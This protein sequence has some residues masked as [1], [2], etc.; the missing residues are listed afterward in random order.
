MPR[1]PLPQLA[2]IT[3]R[4]MCA[5]TGKL[6]LTPPLIPWPSAS[7]RSLFIE[8]GANNSPKDGSR[9]SFRHGAID[10]G[11]EQAD[12]F[13]C[14]PKCVC[15]S[16]RRGRRRTQGRGARRPGPWIGFLAFQ[17]SHARGCLS[18]SSRPWA[19]VACRVCV[20][21]H[22]RLVH[23]NLGALPAS[24]CC[25]SGFTTGSPA[26]G[27]L[28]VAGSLR[29]CPVAVMASCLRRGQCRRR[30]RPCPLVFAPQGHAPC[31]Q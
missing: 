16:E 21:L 6:A 11:R 4:D 24:A 5:P 20:C 19:C 18:W 22:G 10:R 28:A 30:A 1:L 23:G 9:R 29:P 15:F 3:V 2:W 7:A 14:L 12:S 27:R 26:H 8:L 31:S 17:V 25:C 13:V